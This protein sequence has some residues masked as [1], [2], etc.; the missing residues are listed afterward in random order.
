MLTVDFPLVQLHAYNAD[1]VYSVLL[2]KRVSYFAPTKVLNLI[3][4]RA[5]S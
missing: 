3:V 5:K 2:L 1:K 4:T